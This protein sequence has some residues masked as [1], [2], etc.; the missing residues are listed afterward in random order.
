M[1]TALTAWLHLENMLETRCYKPA[2]GNGNAGDGLLG[3]PV[4]QLHLNQLKFI[5]SFPKSTD[6]V[7]TPAIFHVKGSSFP[8]IS[9]P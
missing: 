9:W 8:S 6:H 3:L 2:T 4:Y 1:N 7:P 5:I